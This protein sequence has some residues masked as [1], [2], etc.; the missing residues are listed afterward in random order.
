MKDVQCYDL[1]GG[2]ALKN[3]AFSFSFVCSLYCVENS[4]YC[5]FLHY[6]NWPY[7]A[8][9]CPTPYFMTIVNI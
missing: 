1:F 2:I 7:I 5:F 6:I 3:H 9:I 8:W 4:S